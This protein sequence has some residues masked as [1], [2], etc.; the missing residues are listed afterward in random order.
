[1]CTDHACRECQARGDEGSHRE[2]NSRAGEG[3]GEGEEEARRMEGWGEWG[4]LGWDAYGEED[5]R[6]RQRRLWP[7]PLALNLDHG[8]I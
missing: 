4:G 6:V 7:D 3:E 2:E 1:M 5:S 8:L